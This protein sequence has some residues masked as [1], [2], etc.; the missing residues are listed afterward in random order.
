MAGMPSP[1]DPA[2]EPEAPALPFERPFTKRRDGYMGDSH[3]SLRTREVFK[4]Y[5]PPEGNG[6]QHTDV[7]VPQDEESSPDAPRP[8]KMDSSRIASHDP[9]LACIT[10][11]AAR[12]LNCKRSMITMVG[13][14][15]SYIVAESTRSLSIASPHTSEPGDEIW[16]GS[17]TVV[18]AA[19][20]LCEH[21]VALLP[22]AN[23][24]EQDMLFEIND[25]SQDPQY[26]DAGFVANWPYKRFYGATPLRTRNGVSIG[27]LCVFDDKP[28]PNGLT[29]DERITLSKLGDTVMNYLQVKQ[30]DRDLK[31]GKLMEMGLSKFIA[32][33][34]HP[35][36]GFEMTERREGRLWSEK[37]LEQRRLEETE[38]KKKAEERRT[39][40]QERKF[41][42]MVRE[43]ER[44]WQ[45]EMEKNSRIGKGANLHP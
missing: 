42:Q 6:S 33:G 22:P 2:L 32:E 1:T 8:P 29:E 38:R 21:T 31:K 40:I 41:Q 20:S 12:V 4:Y 25:L 14:A 18:P 34:F 11:L 15:H 9:V 35:V 19:G 17:G 45:R 28:K 3:N 23:P 30:G 7:L 26:R 10:N 43:R 37:I 16:L 36:E 39:M 5:H 13:G 27:T 44:E 24:Y